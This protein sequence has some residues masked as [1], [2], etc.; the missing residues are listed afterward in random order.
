[1]KDSRTKNSVRNILWGVINRIIGIIMPFL[2]RTL[3]IYVLGVQFVGLS[4]LFSS[5]LGVLN[6]AELGIGSAL[7]YTM[8]EPAVNEDTKMLSTLLNFYKRC[9]RII[10]IIILSIGLVIMPFI[11]NFINGQ[12]PA[13]INLYI[14]YGVYL[15]NTVISY[16]MFAYKGAVLTVYQRNDIKSNIATVWQ[17]LQYFIQIMLLL[18]FKNYYAYIIVTPFISIGSNIVTAYY[19]DK[20]YPE[21]ICSGMIDNKIKK[22]IIK[23]IKGM[24]FQKIGNV[25]L[26]SVDNI[27]ISSFLDLSILAIYN[28]YYLI[29]GSLFGILAVLMN[30]IIPSIGN[31]IY[32]K[33]LDENY[34]D[35]KKFNFIYVWIVSWFAVCFLCLSQPFI[36]L[37]LKNEDFLLPDN[38]IFIF[39]CYFFIYKWMD[40]NYV[41]QEAAGLW[42]ENRYIPLIAAIANL[43]VNISLV[44]IIGLSGILI[45][46]IMSTLLIYDVGYIRIIFKYF[47]KRSPKEYIFRQLYYAAITVIVMLITYNICMNIHK[48]GISEIFWKAILC[49]FIPNFIFTI[50]YHKLPE[51]AQSVCLVKKIIKL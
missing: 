43:I 46:T 14:L 2:I 19:T 13:G 37:W 38:L 7:T 51:F 42:W 47:L 11:K 1:M 41:Y 5:I 6:L 22:D 27:V 8:Y 24:F 35:F 29:I 39:V 12:Y 26:S 44:H 10:G 28:N 16:F 45:S 31:A 23:K 21:I 4:S 20:L 34:A 49:I 40:I 3:L 32:T 50:F 33:S 17:L 18:I 48:E 25:V 30:S 36:M 9:Y 15:F